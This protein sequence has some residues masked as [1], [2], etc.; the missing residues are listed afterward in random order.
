VNNCCFGVLHLLGAD[1][2]LCRRDARKQLAGLS[3]SISN[4]LAG[5]QVCGC[6]WLCASVSVCLFLCLVPVLPVW[7]CCMYVGA[8]Q[9]V[10]SNQCHLFISGC[11]W[12]AFPPPPSPPSFTPQMSVQGYSQKLAVLLDLLVDQ[13]A[14]FSVRPDQAMLPSS[15]QHCPTFCRS[16]CRCQFKVTASAVYSITPD[17][18]HC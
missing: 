7:M 18:L 10:A 16:P 1:V 6:V 5:F 9:Q 12:Y 15:P 11:A 8:Q 2:S 14:S 13:L 4:H 3:Y 17:P